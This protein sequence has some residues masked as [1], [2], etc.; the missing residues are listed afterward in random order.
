MGFE[1][2]VQCVGENILGCDLRIFDLLGFIRTPVIYY[3][4][5]AVVLLRFIR[6]VNVRPL[7]VGF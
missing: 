4:S 2:G 5:K 1:V 6:I 3:R 7:S